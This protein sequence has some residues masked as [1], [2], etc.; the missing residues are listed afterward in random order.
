MRHVDALIRNSVQVS[1]IVEK[2]DWFLTVELQD[3]GVREIYSL[4]TNGVADKQTLTDYN[5]N[6]GRIYRKIL[7]GDTYLQL[8]SLA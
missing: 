7:K 2:G 1:A 3:E 6:F 8:L 5:I 4:L